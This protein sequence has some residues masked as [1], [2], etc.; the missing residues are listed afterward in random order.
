MRV[1]GVEARPGAW[2][3][4]PGALER[5]QRRLARLAPTAEPW[6]PASPRDLRVAAVFAALPRGA[7]DRQV[8]PGDPVWVASVLMRERQVLATWV[9][10]GAAG[11]L[12]R[13]GYL[14]LQLGSVLEAAV[15]RL[16]PAPDVLLVNAT[17]R[18]HPRAAGLAL[19]LGAVLD[20]PTVG[21]TDRPLA[22]AG[23]DPGPA[24]GS[25]EPLVLAGDVVGYLV[26]TRPGTHPL[27]VHAAWRTDPETALAVV[28]AVG[29]GHRTP[30]PLRR[31]RRLAR[32]ARSRSDR[33]PRAPHGDRREATPPGGD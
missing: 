7:P 13:P 17:G 12:Y 24:A 30:E 20:L 15:R 26:R 14:A 5:E 6:R 10:R 4:D 25:T 27:V 23:A 3:R 21:V 8:A 33:R 22:A 16:R 32:L 31:A 9:G 18:D 29:S 19:H 2:P 28:L 11:A 1:R